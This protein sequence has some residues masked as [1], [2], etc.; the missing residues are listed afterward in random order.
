MR[1]WYVVDREDDMNIIIQTWD[2]ELK[3]YPDG[4]IKK[5]KSIFCARVDMQLEGI[6]FF[7]TYAP[8]VKCTPTRLMLIL[9]IIL[10]F[11]SKQGD[12]ISIFF[13]AKLEEN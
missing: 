2:F 12:I 4:L 10:Q 1:Y 7:E 6:D 9:E 13:H 8:V 5:F 11:K 3:L